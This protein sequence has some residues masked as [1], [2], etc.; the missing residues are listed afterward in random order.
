MGGVERYWTVGFGGGETPVIF[1]PLVSTSA[2]VLYILAAAVLVALWV[3]R[4]NAEGKTRVLRGALGVVLAGLVGV[5]LAGPAVVEETPALTSN[6]EIVLAID[7]TGSMAAEDGPGETRR[8]DAVKEDIQTIIDTA[9]E[10]RYAV[11]TWDSSARIELPF[12]TD[13]SAVAS[14]AD[15]L[16]QEISEFSTGSTGD[17]PVNEIWGLLESAAEDRPANVRYLV[18]MTDGEIG[19][20]H[21]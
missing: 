15:A 13:T 20:A 12:T 7:R 17:R 11:I 21:V 5:G 4:T 18:V 8:L 16:H 3:A 19:R 9:P 1:K 6:I 10:A 14:L 2:L